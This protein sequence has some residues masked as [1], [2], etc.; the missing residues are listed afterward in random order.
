MIEIAEGL[1]KLMERFD[2]SIVHLDLRDE[3]TEGGV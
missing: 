3:K 2:G 1:K